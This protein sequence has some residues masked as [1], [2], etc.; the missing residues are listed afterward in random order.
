MIFK[1]LKC[2]FCCCLIFLIS[3]LS[4]AQ[5]DTILPQ[6]HQEVQ[7]SNRPPKDP[8]SLSDNSLFHT[9]KENLLGVLLLIILVVTVMLEIKLIKERKM[10][11]DDALKLIIV[12]LIVFGSIFLVVSG[13]LDSQLAPAFGLLGTISGYLLGK[14]DKVDKDVLKDE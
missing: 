8:D 7:V 5:K 13:Y 12:T 1:R 11:D 9:S 3:D 2:F 14:S 6:P 4:Y 10:K